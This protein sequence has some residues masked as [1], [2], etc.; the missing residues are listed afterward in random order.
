MDQLMFLQPMAKPQDGALI[1]YSSM[2]I[3][4]GKLSVDRGIKEGFFHR[5]I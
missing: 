5:Q 3:E 2:G 4:L 1:R